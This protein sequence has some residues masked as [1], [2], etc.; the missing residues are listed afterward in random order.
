MSDNFRL[1]CKG[2]HTLTQCV[3]LDLSLKE[4]VCV[5]G[6][7]LASFIFFCYQVEAMCLDN[8]LFRWDSAP[9]SRIFTPNAFY[10]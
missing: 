8:H 7:V 6:V 5:I 1:V 10:T 2:E 4:P 3:P 9:N